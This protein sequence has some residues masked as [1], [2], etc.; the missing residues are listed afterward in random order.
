[1]NN[2]NFTF[3]SNHWNILS[4]LAEMAER[5]MYTDPN[6]SLMKLRMFGETMTKFICALEEMRQA[7][8]LN[9]IDRLNFLSRE[10]L[11]TEELLDM[12]H[13][14]RKQGNKAAHQGNYG[15]TEEAKALVHF[16]FRLAV[17]FMQ[18]Y[19]EW[20]FTAPEY[21]EPAEA[22]DTVYNEE[23]LQQLSASYDAKV[24]Q[25]EQELLRLTELQDSKTQEEKQK[26]HSKARKLGSA[27]QLTE[28]ETRMII[29]E[30]LRQA[31]WEADTIQLRFSA[32][33]RPEKGR[34]LAIAEWP[35]KNGF[36]DYALFYGMELIGIIEA[37]R[38]SKD[39]QADIEQAKKYASYVIKHGEEIIHGPWGIIR[40]RSCFQQMGDPI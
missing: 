36:A 16:A 27:L 11:L 10:D 37:K 21:V 14:I 24:Q 4:N 28:A 34:Y 30:K 32:G 33:T 3:L 38:Q 5:N 7:E 40:F 2:S 18:V 39:V 13:A 31:G 17:W 19:G 29:D 25:L 26:R 1:M 12:L 20:D 35:L 8:G 9:Q 23:Q 15:T 22:D 6:T